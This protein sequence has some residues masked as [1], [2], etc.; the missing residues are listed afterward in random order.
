[1]VGIVIALVLL[2]IVAIGIGWSLLARKFRK[3]RLRAIGTIVSLV[4]AIVGTLVVQNVF[5]GDEFVETQLLPWINESLTPEFAELLA[6]SPTLRDVVLGCASALVAPLLFFVFFLVASFLAWIVYLLIVLIRGAAMKE[7]DAD[8][9]YAAPRALVWAVIQALIIVVV[10]LVPISAYAEIAPILTDKIVEAEIL[11]ENTNDV[12]QTISDEY[13]TPINDNVL[14]SLFRVMGGSAITDSLTSFDVNGETA[15]LKEEVGAVASL[16]CDVFKLTKKEF[17]AYGSAEADLLISIAA[18]FE[19]SEML[20]AIAGELIYNATDAWLKGEAFIGITPD[21]LTADETGM[22]NDFVNQLLNILHNDAK[23]TDALCADVTT[24]AKLMSTL[25]NAE[26]FSSL[27]DQDA[28]IGIL[29]R[30]G[31]VNALITDLGSNNSMKVLIGEITNIGV[32]AIATTLGIKE[33][34]DTAYN[35]ML[36]T[37]AAELNAVKGMSSAEQVQTLTTTLNTAFNDAGMVVDKQVLDFYSGTM[38]DSLLE[39]A[40]DEEITAESVKG[41]FALYAWSV[42]EYAEEVEQIEANQTQSSTHPLSATTTLAT[43]EELLQALLVGTV[44]EGKSI[45]ELKNCGPAVL[46]RVT[47]KLSKIEETP[48]TTIAE[49]AKAIV[50]EEYTALLVDESKQ[51]LL[52]IMIS[53]EVKKPVPESS[54]TN[55]SSLQTS[56]TMKETTVLVTLD[57]LLVDTAA[58]AENINADTIANEAA[59]IEAIFNTA[60]ALLEETSSSESLDIGKVA[61][62]VG[63]ILDNLGSTASFGKEQTGQLFTAVLQSETVRGTAGLDIST[64][65]QLGEKGS[66]G[67]NVNYEQTFQTVTDTVTIMT[68]MN[69]GTLTEEEIEKMIRNINPQTAG[70]IEVYVTVERM[71][72]EFDVPE[73]YA[74]TAA[75]LISNIFKFMGDSDMDEAQYAAEAKA[76][77]DIMNVTMAASENANEGQDSDRLFGNA[78]NSILGKTAFE[79]VE[80]FMSSH[81]IAFSLRETDFE[82]DP[83]KLSESMHQS[84]DEDEAEELKKG[85]HD[86]Y[87]IPENRTEENKETLI[88]LGMLFGFTAEEVNEILAD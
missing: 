80:I 12:V 67:D 31:L 26:V 43:R 18:S 59:A 81:A 57:K 68:N 35:E 45:E 82:A 4:V 48:E 58:T 2:G 28:L 60:G 23:N 33:D 19:D 3:T 75:P 16:G 47:V 71:T 79:T 83:F 70:M 53:V 42:A 29:S 56:E 66:S 41:F 37:I 34:A 15:L 50:E 27:G 72:D 25:I 85:I 38:I 61:G 77:N 40:G 36:D 17:S 74:K 88:L 30:E 54:I 69:D 1:M 7:K 8:T 62:S 6:Q 86:Y 39:E 78:E 87:N 21:F 84:E 63:A 51:E 55:T 9:P 46:A 52:Q 13:I 44:Y 20:P 65:T 5:F 73:E 14:V 64:A 76:I 22:F 11:D 49:Q 10:T 32:R 24:V